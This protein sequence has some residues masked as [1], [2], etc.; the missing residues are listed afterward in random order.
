MDAKQGK[1]ARGIG[2]LTFQVAVEVVGETRTCFRVRLPAGRDGIPSGTFLAKRG[3]VKLDA[4][5]AGKAV[6][7]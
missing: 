6:G 4:P 7:A 2:M 1:M 5:A 3:D